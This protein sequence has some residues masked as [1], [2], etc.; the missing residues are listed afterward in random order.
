VLVETVERSG[1]K[2]DVLRYIEHLNSTKACRETKERNL[3]LCAGSR[4]RGKVNVIFMIIT[5]DRK[6]IQVPASGVP[7]HARCEDP[8]GDMQCVVNEELPGN[9]LAKAW[10]DRAT[11]TADNITSLSQRLTR[12]ASERRILQSR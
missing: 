3:I 10:I 4:D 12:F 8:T 5:D 6:A 11:L 1:P 2:S 7:I 9:V